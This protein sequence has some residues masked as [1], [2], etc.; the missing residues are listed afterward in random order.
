MQQRQEKIETV[1]V[2][3][4]NRNQ[5][6]TGLSMHIYVNNFFLKNKRDPVSGDYPTPVRIPPLGSPT[7]GKKCGV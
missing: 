6:T 1:T 5:T 3:I 7:P 2:Y 4:T